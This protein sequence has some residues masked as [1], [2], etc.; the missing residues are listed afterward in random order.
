VG[1]SSGSSP[2]EAKNVWPTKIGDHL[3][4]T[5]EHRNRQRLSILIEPSGA[6]ELILNLMHALAS[7][8]PTAARALLAHLNELAGTDA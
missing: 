1:A 2:T 5:V 4:L 3:F 6:P 7:R 8:D